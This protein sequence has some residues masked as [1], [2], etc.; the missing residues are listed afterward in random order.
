[1]K[2]VKV[3]AG[4]SG[5]DRKV[6]YV[7]VM[8][9][10][11]IKNWLK[12]NDFLI[13]SFYSVRK[14]EEEQCRLVKELADTCS[15]IAVKTGQY[16]SE[17]AESVKRTADECG[18]PIL[19]IPFEKTYIDMII[20]IMNLI[21]GEEGR[22][23]ILEKYI[24]DII[25]ENYNDEILMKE[26]GNLFGLEVDKNYF[27][28]VNVSFKK[29]YVLTQAD[30]K[31]LRSFSQN[32]IH[33]ISKGKAV[34]SC[35]KLTL[36]KGA[37]FL[38]EGGD[39]KGLEKSLKYYLTEEKIRILWDKQKMDNVTCAVGPVLKGMKGIRDT[40]SLSYQAMH[41]GRKLYENQVLHFYDKLKIFCLLEEMMLKDE[42]N[43]LTSVLEPLKNDE[44]LETL[45]NYYECGMKL[46]K[47]A[48]KIYTHKNTV[49]YRMHRI[50]EQ[51]GVDL[52]NPD[53][54]FRVY[55]A[56]LA[57]KLKSQ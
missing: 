50:Q 45:K 41:M 34:R 18:L 7:T 3:V 24:K 44:L 31:N 35:Y 17:I 23:E 37:L 19:E 40:Y 46:D 12:G 21:F 26:R 5:L 9:V 53:D 29:K 36:E 57:M 8:E 42:S 33:H 27:V 20:S 11:D 4:S 55:L 39:E 15:C 1:M 6:E 43:H 47:V 10:P 22:A 54:N 2:G 52:K 25:Y 32:F 51:M 48:E 38:I 13:T 14:S 49:K 16:V 30:H 56:I 28:A